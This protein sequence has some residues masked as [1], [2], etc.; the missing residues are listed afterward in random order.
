MAEVPSTSKKGCLLKGWYWNS[1]RT[2]EFDFSESISCNLTLHAVWEINPNVPVGPENP[3]V[4][5]NPESP[6]DEENKYS[7]EYKLN[8]GSWI[9]SLE[10]FTVRNAG[11]TIIFPAEENISRQG[12]AFQGWFE[13]DDDGSTLKGGKI[14]RVESGT[15]RFIL[16]T[17]TRIVKKSLPAAFLL[18]GI[19]SQ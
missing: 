19:P 6:A 7:I 5:E 18:P 11:E 14:E 4:P 3:E 13:S 1:A 15:A 9:A 8:G 10:A 2:C 12:Y 17:Q 16:A